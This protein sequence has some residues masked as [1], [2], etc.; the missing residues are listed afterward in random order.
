MLED[1]INGK[2]GIDITGE[3]LDRI[4]ELVSVLMN[5][6]LANDHTEENIFKYLTECYG[7]DWEII[8]IRSSKVLDAW[9]NEGAARFKLNNTVVSLD[10][11]LMT[12]TIEIKEND[13]EN[14]FI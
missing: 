11:F 12:E 7:D 4:L 14:L 5:S 1:F 13:F 3:S 9:K 10:T 8:F 2:I 6:V